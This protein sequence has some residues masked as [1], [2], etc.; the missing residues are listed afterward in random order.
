MNESSWTDCLKLN[1]ARKVIS[2]K[3]RAESL[4]ETA[5][6]RI[7]QIGEITGK[8]CNYV[9]EDYYT[10]IL[11]FLQAI[12]F[13]QGFNILNHVCIGYFLKEKL[14]RQDLFIIFDDLRY[15]RNSL[16]YY[17]K[18]MEF[19][20]CKEAINKSKLLLNELDKIIV[21]LKNKNQI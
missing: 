1:K 20:V 2:D 11:E 4:I 5:I 7:E 16:T 18:R 9:F 12:G 8:N 13:W 10:S 21:V 14:Q 17:G 6:G 19:D 15:K 3:R